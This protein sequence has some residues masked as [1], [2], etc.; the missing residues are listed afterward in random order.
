MAASK[1]K[2]SKNVEVM[3]STWEVENSHQNVPLN[4]ITEH[5]E[6]FGL[7]NRTSK[8]ELEVW[9]EDESSQMNW[10][11]RRKSFVFFWGVK[12][13]KKRRKKGKK[14][15]TRQ[16]GMTKNWLDSKL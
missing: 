16:M 11:S 6:F 2:S 1:L 14:N 3:V 8:M 13:M 9:D 10:E 5:E 7:K 15:V 4:I 12:R